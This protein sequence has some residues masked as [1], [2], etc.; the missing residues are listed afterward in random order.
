[1]STATLEAPPAVAAPASPAPA[2][3]AAP[4]APVTPAQLNVQ[5]FLADAEKAPAASMTALLPAPEPFG[6]KPAVV[7]PVVAPVPDP[8]T[9]VVPAPAAPAVEAPATTPTAETA[10]EAATK[11]L[12]P[13]GKPVIDSRNWRVRANDA[14]EAMVY[15]LVIQEKIPLTEAMKEVYGDQPSAPQSTSGQPT[16]PAPTAAVIDPVAEADTFISKLSDEANA[17]SAAMKKAVEANDLN[18]YHEANQ[19]FAAKQADLA[20][21]KLQRESIRQAQQDA[22]VNERVDNHRQLVETNVTKAFGLYPKLT[23]AK[24]PE[25]AQFNLK[26]AELEKDPSFGANFRQTTPGWPLMVAR[27]VAEE[28]GW[29]RQPISPPVASVPAAAPTMTNPLAVQPVAAPVQPRATAVELITS[30]AN[31][32]SAPPKVDV[33]SFLRDS[34]NATPEQ[35]MDLLKNAPTDWLQKMEAKNRRD[36]RRIQQ[37][38]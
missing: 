30:S 36:P 19:S 37:A 13:N 27:M 31:P 22:V 9:P 3:V 32:G 4:V 18:A 25:R 28:Q 24:S 1:M 10:L 35:L 8:A 7:A 33:H 21:A 38:R 17:L 16:G 12:A 2:P 23:E 29:S 34:A 26:V 14:K 15:Q 6:R 5:S 11:A 20:S